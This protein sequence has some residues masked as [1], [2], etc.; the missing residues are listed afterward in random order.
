MSDKFSRRQALESV[1]AIVAGTV[2]GSAMANGQ[3]PGGRAPLDTATPRLAP[4]DELVNVLEFEEEA[5]KKLAPAT[6]ALIA[7][8]DRALM[9]R[10]TL[11]PRMLAPTLDMDLSVTLFG[12]QHFTPILLGPMADQKRF[13]P[14]GEL[15]TAKGAAAAK[16][17]MIVSSRSSVPLDQIAAVAKPSFW[18]QVFAADNA[19]KQQV[20]DAV[21]AGA[22]AI[23]ITV[24]AAP[25]VNGPRVATSSAINWSAVDAIR[26]GVNVPVLVKGIT[27]P[28]EATAALQHN[29]QGIVVSNYGGLVAGKDAMILT[30]PNVVDAVAGKVPVLTDGSFRRG[31]DV[32]KALALGAQG[33]LIGRPVMWGLA[34]YGDGGVQSVVEMLQT[35]LGRYMGM[36]GKSNLKAL[37]R[38][39]VKVHGPL[40]AK[41]ATTNN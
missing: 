10:I 18:Y 34:A 27:T 23:V 7:G 14:D 3:A 20:Q 11:R 36:C 40:P 4:R 35:E 37:G 39:L 12:E 31:T 26:Q 15:A 29:V 30:L 8:G 19:A 38:D 24:G 17:L 32:L 16:A 21:K 33:V 1:G 22:K 25:T 5:K 13:H 2:A 28:A 41:T 6:Y 9:D